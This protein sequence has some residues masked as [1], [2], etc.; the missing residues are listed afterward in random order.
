MKYSLNLL[1]LSFLFQISAQNLV[2]NPSFEE[3]SQCPDQLNQ[4]PY[5]TGWSSFGS[6]P[7][8]YNACNYSSLFNSEVYAVPDNYYG[9]QYA[10]EGSA[11]CGLISWQG[12]GSN[13]REM[14]GAELITPL[15][16]GIT[17]FVSLKFN[18]PY[19]EG[20]P[21]WNTAIKNL[22]VRFTNFQ[23]S[24]NSPHP[25][26]D[27]CHVCSNQLIMDTL[28]WIEVSGTFIPD[29]QYNYIVIGNFYSDATTDTMMLFAPFNCGN[30]SSYYVDEICVSTNS[31]TC[32]NKPAGLVENTSMEKQL[33]R[34][35]D[36]MGRETDYSPNTL[37]IYI[38]SDGTTEK[39]FR[40]E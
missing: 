17:Y 25:V 24:E 6:T 10:A 27:S 21:C 12:D 4:V 38:F 31:L 14:I 30:C 5:A 23:Y 28:N 22:G 36:I 34:I 8:Y 3:F 13:I 9:F 26:D 1:F 32:G 15:D 33:I 40:V 37:L 39:V 11:Y 16:S 18:F 29:Q 20:N 2:P 7:D 19:R 35:V